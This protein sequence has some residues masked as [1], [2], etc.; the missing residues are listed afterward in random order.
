MNGKT[1]FVRHPH[2]TPGFDQW[3]Q[4]IIAIPVDMVLSALRE[5]GRVSFYTCDGMNGCGTLKLS[6][7][8]TKNFVT[9]LS[10]ILHNGKEW[11]GGILHGSHWQLADD[12]YADFDLKDMDQAEEYRSL[13]II[14][15]KPTESAVRKWL[16]GQ[17]WSVLSKIPKKYLGCS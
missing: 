9:Q 3:E 11:V 16:R 13:T 10:H 2:Y 8:D 6:N 5:T 12:I 4:W 17:G 14:D 1:I 7:G 15:C